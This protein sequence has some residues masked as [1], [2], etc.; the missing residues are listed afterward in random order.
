MTCSLCNTLLL[1]KLD[2]DYYTCSCCRAWVKD[3]SL[4][5]KPEEEQLH[6]LSHNNDTNDPRYKKFTSPI[7]NYI[8]KN[9]GKE[10]EGLDFGSGTGPVISG[11]LKDANYRV[12]Q[13]DPFFANFPK[14]LEQQYDYAFAC[15]VVE[16]FKNPRDEF[17]KLYKLLKPQG[18]LL[19]MT[20]LFED[21]I[22]FKTWYYRKDPT[23]VFIYRRETFEYISAEFNFTK[24][25]IEGRLVVLS[26]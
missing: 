7:S 4:Y 14:V 18:K 2:E 3:K 10:Q 20:H 19:I 13:F 15:E 9:F 16:H 12:K 6:Y 25:E 21:N 24:C 23:H 5:L 22:E 26:K 11:V 17:Q 1:D 8:L